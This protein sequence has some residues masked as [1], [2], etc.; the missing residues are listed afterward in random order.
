MC[1]MRGE[2][3]S[4]GCD[5]TTWVLYFVFRQ[6]RQPMVWKGPDIDYNSIPHI[7]QISVE[8][9]RKKSSVSCFCC[10]LKIGISA[11]SL[12]FFASSQET[13]VPL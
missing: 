2:G 13:V 7:S 9:N 3:R 5:V 10:S 1:H 11:K 8:G 12:K 4:G 6:W